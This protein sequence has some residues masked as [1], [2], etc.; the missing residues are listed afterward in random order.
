MHCK[1]N[2]S[3]FASHI[4]GPSS[5]H[6][7]LEIKNLKCPKYYSQ[8][9][10]ANSKKMLNKISILQTDFVELSFKFTLIDSNESSVNLLF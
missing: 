7:V 10:I 6:I 4:V 1:L 9:H 3:N 2:S 8:A 5:G